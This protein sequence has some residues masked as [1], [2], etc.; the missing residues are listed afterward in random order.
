M[1]VMEAAIE[2][3]TEQEQPKLVTIAQFAEAHP[4]VTEHGIRFWGL[5]VS[6][7]Q[8]ILYIVAA[9]KADDP[10]S[11]SSWSQWLGPFRE[12]GLG[13]ILMGIV[14]ALYSIGNVLAFQFDR[15]K[16]IIG[17]GQ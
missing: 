3:G 16:S 2:P 8:F 15:V 4:F 7:L 14:L 5:M 9:G 1:A 12:I 6:I 13:L 10:A 17:T 11:F